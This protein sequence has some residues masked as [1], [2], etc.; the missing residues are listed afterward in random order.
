MVNHFDYVYRSM[1]P[2]FIRKQTLCVT[3]RLTLHRLNRCFDRSSVGVEEVTFGLVPSVA[4]VH[5]RI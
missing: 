5:V 3:L 2:S 1:T 4:C